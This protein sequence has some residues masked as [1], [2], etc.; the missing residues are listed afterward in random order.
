MASRNATIDR[1]GVAATLAKPFVWVYAAI[2][3][4][5]MVLVWMALVNLWFM[6][7]VW[8]AG[9]GVKIAAVILESDLAAAPQP[10]GGRLGDLSYAAIFRFSGIE[11]AVT[12]ATTPG[13]KLS[14]ADEML[15]RVFLEPCA[16]EIATL[17]QSARLIGV[18]IALFLQVLLTG[19]VAILAALADGM[20]QRYIRRERAGRESANLYHRAKHLQLVGGLLIAMLYVTVPVAIDPRWLFGWVGIAAFLA[21][22]QAKFYKKYL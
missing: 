4:V 6:H 17:M 1:I 20:V 12:A 3:G 9:Q 16:E 19:L 15:V 22:L 8:P 14:A 18:R 11:G 21:F 2:L 7:A 10:L 5:F 13:A